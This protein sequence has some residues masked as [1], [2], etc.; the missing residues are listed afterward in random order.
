MSSRVRFLPLLVAAVACLAGS[1]ASASAAG[2]AF[3]KGLNKVTRV[4]GTVPANGDQNPYGIT[5]V[6]RSTGSLVAGDTLVSNFN[7]KENL[8]G[9]GSTIVQ[10]SPSGSLS[11]FAELKA[12]SLPGPCPG[13]VGLTTALTVLPGGFVVVGSVPSTNGKAATSGAGCLIVLNS[14]GQPVETISGPPIN[15]P[16]DLTASS[17]RFIGGSFNILYVSNVLNGTVAAEGKTV[18]GG[19]VAR[20][21]LFD[22]PGSP[23][24]VL[25]DNVIAEGFPERT[26][27]AA[28]VVG[29]TGL[30][31]APGPSGEETL[32]VADTVDNRIA[33]VSN[34]LFRFT[35]ATG[36][37]RTVTQG[38]DI[39][40]PLGMTATPNGDILTANAEN[41][42]LVE[43]APNG[44]EVA[45]FNTG[46]GP[47]GL[48]GITLTP[49]QRGVL[50]VNDNE[51]GLDLL[52]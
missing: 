6:P 2:N 42:K 24:L 33:A 31:V 35:P 41:A 37:G 21:V 26:D 4:G 16:W 36:A 8:Q 49:D 32:Y 9:T 39:N 19:T 50:F 51:N 17:F 3:L 34:P 25:S 27:E 14:E 15:G 22:M 48:F 43:T 47:G 10:I 18:D 20:L 29:P 45:S 1:P 38:G 13:G 23:P 28:F 40:D 11:V 30:A 12:S 52:H 44:N 7:N 5:T 46:I